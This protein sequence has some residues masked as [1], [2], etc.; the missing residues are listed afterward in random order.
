[1][2]CGPW[3]RGGRPAAPAAHLAVKAR[4]SDPALARRTARRCGPLH[5]SPRTISVQQVSTR[6][7]P[8]NMARSPPVRWT[9][10]RRSGSC[11]PTG[12]TLRIGGVE[13]HPADVF[14]DVP[15]PLGV[16]L[17]DAAAPEVGDH[18]WREITIDHYFPD[19]VDRCCDVDHAPHKTR[20]AVGVGLDVHKGAAMRQQFRSPARGRSMATAGVA[21][22]RWAASRMAMA[23]R[24]RMSPAL[25]M[26]RLR[27]SPASSGVR[28][29]RRGRPG[30][31]DRRDC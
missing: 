13:G 10:I 19:H 5:S 2:A 1:M 9:L 27:R 23:G 14:A 31:R 18:M 4:R 29:A 21:A 3:P 26:S 30:R 8:S 12:K 28:P 15:S 17:H 11:N 24:A 6:H 16:A 22:K 25:P 7:S 20:P